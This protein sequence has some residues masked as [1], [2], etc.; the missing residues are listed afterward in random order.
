MKCCNKQGCN[1]YI[2]SNCSA[3]ENPEECEWYEPL[4]AN[5]DAVADVRCNEGLDGQELKRQ[6][7][8]LLNKVNAVTCQ[9]RHRQKVTDRAL[10]ELSNRQL[11]VEKALEAM[12]D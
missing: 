3:Y 2:S 12:A 11:D 5:N 9:Y 8:A 4:I 6:L 1:E 10:T 7:R